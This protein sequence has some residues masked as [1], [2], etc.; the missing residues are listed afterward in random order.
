MNED[1]WGIPLAWAIQGKRPRAAPLA[2]FE[3]RFP[4]LKEFLAAPQAEFAAQPKSVSVCDL[5]RRFEHG[6]ADIK[7][8]KTEK[9]E[10]AYAIGASGAKV[11]NVA[12]VMLVKKTFVPTN[13]LTRDQSKLSGTRIRSFLTEMSVG[14]HMAAIS[15]DEQTLMK[16][17]HYCCVPRGARMAERIPL[18]YAFLMSR[19]GQLHIM[20]VAASKT[21]DSPAMLALLAARLMQGLARLH[22]QMT[23][24]GDLHGKNILMQRSETP[25]EAP[26]CMIIDYGYSIMLQHPFV[27]WNVHALWQ[28]AW[29]TPEF[30]LIFRKHVASPEELPAAVVSAAQ[31]TA[32]Y[33]VDPSIDVFRAGVVLLML[34]GD[35]L[36]ARRDVRTTVH[37]E[38]ENTWKFD[39]IVRTEERKKTPLWPHGFRDLVSEHQ[40]PYGGI[41]N[42]LARCIKSLPTARPTAAEAASELY[43][44]AD[45][46]AEMP[47]FKFAFDFGTTYDHLENGAT[48]NT[49]ELMMETL[50]KQIP[51]H[52]SASRL[53]LLLGDAAYIINTIIAAAGSDKRKLESVDRVA[54][55]VEMLDQFSV[56]PRLV[57]AQFHGDLKAAKE[58]IDNKLL[59]LIQNIG[60]KAVVPSLGSLALY[61]IA[62]HWLWKVNDEKY[63]S[64]LNLL[65]AP[66]F[67]HPDP[68]ETYVTTAGA[69]RPPGRIL[70]D[71]QTQ[72][73]AYV[74]KKIVER[75]S[76]LNAVIDLLTHVDGIRKLTGLVN[77]YV[78]S[79]QAQLRVQQDAARRAAF[80]APPCYFDKHAALYTD[81]FTVIDGR[82]RELFGSE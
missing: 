37:E 20:D 15:P 52:L 31:E 14:A 64:M 38:L 5:C 3:T 44:L 8:Y 29:Q 36:Y 59:F 6:E 17:T 72:F 11:E 46:Q 48:K 68:G 7:E 65:Y 62:A 51:D 16:T 54:S 70:T 66:T 27:G 74:A 75:N 53:I 18:Q 60:G 4:N 81:I 43:E 57:T 82:A 35:I 34:T 55:V 80:N 22:S 71:L 50:L 79:T 10:E 49:F 13:F 78:E 69:L 32:Q 73:D 61:A 23:V 45:M 24:H 56:R 19:G 41:I 33:L 63:I 30:N 47:L 40:G 42:I 25:G 9:E 67:G 39:Q 28:H 76:L 77:Q 1:A 2:P 58:D 26:Q 21:Y 12:G